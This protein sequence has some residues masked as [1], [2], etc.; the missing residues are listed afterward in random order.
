MTS[1]IPSEP[2]TGPQL[3]HGGANA[4]AGDPITSAD[5]WSLLGVGIGMIYGVQILLASVG[6]G[7]V[8]P[9]AV[10]D[11]ACIACF[12]VYA[13]KRRIG[14]RGLGFTNVGGLWYVAAVLV[15]AS[16][17]YVNLT[18]VTLLHVPE[19]PS[20]LLQGLVE[21][22]PLVSTLAALAVL[23]PFAEEIV[24]RGVLA[25]GLATARPTWQAV[26]ISSAVF[27]AYHILPA[28]A[29]ATFLLGCSLA[30]LTL[31]SRSIVPAIIVHFLNNV[32]AI[33]VSRE[34]VPGFATWMANHPA[35]MLS[36]AVT[37]L[38]GGLAI[39]AN[40]PRQEAAA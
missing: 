18:I 36:T 1:P 40:A 37:L 33:I 9:S 29:A 12:W 3:Y 27:G 39:A 4:P 11:V 21:K 23:P 15:G 7:G 8:V 35:V 22:T 25:R 32:I 13:R 5:A 6:V 24:F 16:A 14:A 10:S 28:Q 19:G 30:Y 2:R 31:R 17:W 38:V 20:E 34:S 26:L